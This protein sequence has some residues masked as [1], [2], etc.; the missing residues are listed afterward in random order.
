MF[1]LTVW[2][3]VR[4]PKD[5][6]AEYNSSFG[7]IWNKAS[8]GPGYLI[9]HARHLRYR[10]KRAASTTPGTLSKEIHRYRVEHFQAQAPKA[11][12]YPVEI[13]SKVRFPA[14]NAQLSEVQSWPNEPFSIA[15]AIILLPLMIDVVHMTIFLRAMISGKPCVR[16]T[17]VTK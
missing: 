17:R 1:A 13:T 7:H 9:S 6:T 14:S 11:L 8:R 5:L 3:M 12:G 10:S 16:V 15:A 2:R 4:Q